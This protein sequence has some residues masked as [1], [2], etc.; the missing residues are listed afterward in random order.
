MKSKAYINIKKW[1]AKPVIFLFRIHAH[2]SENE[3]R[4]ED[5]PYIIAANH[6][7]NADPIFLCAATDFQ[8]PHFMA[9]KE[10][11]KVPLLNK[12]VTALGAYPVDRKGADVGAI[13]KTIKM[14]EEGKCIGIFPQGHRNKGVD[15]RETEVKSGLGMIAA[16]SGATVLPC[17]IKMKKRRWAPFRRVD[18]YIGKPIRPE[19]INYDPE[20]KGE[21]VR[22]SQ[23][24]FDRICEIG[25]SVDAAENK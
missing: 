2:S 24:V 1:L 17:F 12:L 23:M 4:E 8:Q 16:K 13:R 14:L 22:I 15:P 18:V 11:F 25:E 7:S 9:K 3:P 5:G 21:Y 10:L 6:I 20:G 19:E